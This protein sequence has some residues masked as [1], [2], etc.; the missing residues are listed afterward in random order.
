[1]HS[2]LCISG[3]DPAGHSGLSAD[4]R[5]LAFLGVRAMPVAATLTVQNL[6]SFSELRPVPADLLSK[7][8]RKVLEEAKPD[9]VKIGMMANAETAR[10]VADIVRNLDIP[11]VTD[12]VFASSSG[13]NLLDDELLDAY[14]HGLV[15][16]SAL[17]TP[18]A[19]EASALTDLEVRN[20]ETAAIACKA[21]IELGAKAALV[22]G[23][24]FSESK[25]TDVFLDSEGKY[26]LAGQGALQDSRGTGCTY[27]AMIAGHIARGS[28]TREA[29][30][31][32]KKDMA[33]AM[34]IAAWQGYGGAGPGSA[35]N[36]E[37]AAHGYEMGNAVSELVSILPPG[38]IAEVGNNLAFGLAGAKGPEGICSLDSRIN[39]KG[40]RVATLG[41][42]VFGRD[43]HVGRVVLAAMSHDPQ[44]RCAL[45]LRY[46]AEL[47]GDITKAGFT[48]GGFD[49][50]DEPKSSSSME[51]GTAKAIKDLGY[52]PDAIHDP[53]SCGKE[54]MIRLLAHDPGELVRKLRR[55]LEMGQ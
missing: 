34:D 5:A 26:N 19:S 23:G 27:S 39:L 12:P 48:V 37:K 40:G 53:G 30:N 49:R 14:R 7:Q 31:R 55:I 9:A 42:P 15:P 4:I 3:L 24:H 1:M 46:S 32:A 10:L 13:F 44:I 43:S 21:I 8:I 11:A 6:A 45:N 17:L 36:G 54:P 25:G 20:P 41:T 52:V 38:C 51:W 33:R 18:N 22:K 2:V 50:K 35:I 47:L 29:V 16:V 28:G